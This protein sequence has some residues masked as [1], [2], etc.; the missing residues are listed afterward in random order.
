MSAFNHY[1][2]HT[3]DVKRSQNPFFGNREELKHHFY[4]LRRQQIPLATF[5]KHFPV[6]LYYDLFVDILPVLI[7][8]P[9]FALP[10]RIWFCMLYIRFRLTVAE[11]I[12]VFNQH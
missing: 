4:L 3:K 8:T 6:I 11:M 1:V 12:N 7:T 2:F 10:K 5:P 9:G